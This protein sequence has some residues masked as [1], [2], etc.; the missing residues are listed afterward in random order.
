MTPGV[1]PSLFFNVLNGGKH[2]RRQCGHT[3]IHDSLRKGSAR[4]FREALRI[5]AETYH[6]L[7]SV[8]K[9]KKG[10]AP[11]S[12]T[13]EKPQRRAFRQTKKRYSSSSP[14]SKEP[15]TL[16]GRISV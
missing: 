12:A 16:P 8:L 13:R 3:G 2:A 14:P 15:V 10:S 9:A 6:T 4:S 1:C 7:K 11:L 5:A